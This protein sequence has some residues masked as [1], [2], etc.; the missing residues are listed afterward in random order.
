MVGTNGGTR[1]GGKKSLICSLPKIFICG[2]KAKR[3]IKKKPFRR[4]S[5]DNREN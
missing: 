2:S 3:L 4:Y 1:F 5:I